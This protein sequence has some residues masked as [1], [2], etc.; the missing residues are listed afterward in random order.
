MGRIHKSKKSRI[1]G[2]VCGGLAEAME[3][4]PLILRIVTIIFIPFGG[5]S[6]LVYLV[7]CLV[8]PSEDAIEVQKLSNNTPSQGE[9]CP[10]C[11]NRIPTNASVCPYCGN[12]R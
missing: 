7:L 2:G 1:I 9:Y 4:S 10:H 11:G 12:K 5:I 8:L 6:V 3:I